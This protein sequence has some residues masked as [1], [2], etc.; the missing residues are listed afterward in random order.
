FYRR[1][2]PVIGN[3]LGE[4]GRLFAEIGYGQARAVQEILTQA[5][6]SVEIRRDYRQIERIV[7]ARKSETVRD[8]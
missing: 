1:L 7:I 3:W 4:G 5:Q 8:A 2:A 6:L